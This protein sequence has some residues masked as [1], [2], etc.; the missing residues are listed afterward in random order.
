VSYQRTVTAD[1]PD[2]PLVTAVF[3]GTSNAACF[4]VEERLPALVQA[5]NV[6]SDGV[7]HAGSA[8]VRW[9]C[10]RASAR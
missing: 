6:S 7:W 4:T 1:L 8:A 9:G 10:Y 3:S 2:R 5:T